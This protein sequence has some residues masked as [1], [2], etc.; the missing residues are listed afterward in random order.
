M[1]GRRPGRFLLAVIDG[2]GTLPPALGLAG[3]L[4]RRG[5]SV[6]VLG[7]PTAEESARAAGCGFTAWPTAPRIDTI[8]EQTALI[9][10]LESGNP[11]H[12]FTAARDRILVGPAAQFADDVVVGRGAA[13]RGARLG[14]S[15]PPPGV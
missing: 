5:H 7:D 12:Q 14:D 4:V 1:A 9:Q 6:E 15:L 2:G 13:R 11:L 10:Q 8:A 3:E